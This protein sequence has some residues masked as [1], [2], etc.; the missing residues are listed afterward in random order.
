MLGQLRRAGAGEGRL[1]PSS[2]PAALAERREGTVEHHDAQQTTVRTLFNDIKTARRDVALG[3]NNVPGIAG[4]SFELV[5][6]ARL[7]DSTTG[8][9]L[10]ELSHEGSKSVVPAEPPVFVDQ[11]DIV[12]QTPLDQRAPLRVV[13]RVP[14]V[15]VTAA[16]GRS[17]S[18]RDRGLSRREL[19]RH[20]PG[21]IGSS[22]GAERGP[23]PD[24]SGW[25]RT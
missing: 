19:A 11:L 8:D 7:D 24:A 22:Y 21:F 10:M 9:R 5:E 18:P 16:S 14:R 20:S 17:V 1:T 3:I 12:G 23:N 13:G 25:A 4:D 15:K 6:A 2:G